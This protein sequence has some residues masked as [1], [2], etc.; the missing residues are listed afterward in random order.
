[1]FLNHELKI[2]KQNLQDYIIYLISIGD[3]KGK[4]EPRLG[5]YYE[6]PEILKTLDED[7]IEVFKMN[8][9]LYT[10][11]IRLKSFLKQ[12]YIIFAFIAA[13]LSITYT[14]YQFTGGNPVVIA[15][16]VV[17]ILFLVMYF[18]FIREKEEKVKFKVPED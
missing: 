1:G 17:T 7:D 3:L 15:F 16:P 10:R 11:Y 2:K 5:L 12:N 4:Y 9:H 13:V 6:N 14:L 18:F 8:F